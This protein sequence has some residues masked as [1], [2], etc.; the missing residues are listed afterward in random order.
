MERAQAGAISLEEPREL[1]EPAWRVTTV[2]K[3]VVLFTALF[4]VLF[5]LYWIVITS[6]KLRPE[7]FVT[8]PTFFPLEPTLDN[9]RNLFLERNVGQ[10][11][12]NSAIVVTG[13]VIA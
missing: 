3:Y 11:M 4:L 13:S 12:L 5:P 9:Y 1:S 6:F 7:I 8:T 10:F 2:L